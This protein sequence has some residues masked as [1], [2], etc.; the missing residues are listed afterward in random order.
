MNLRT[1]III[2]SMGAIVLMGSNSTLAVNMAGG[3]TWGTPGNAGSPLELGSAASET[4]FLVGV[5][6][7]LRG[8]NTSLDNTKAWAQVYISDGKWWIS[9]RAGHGSGVK[10]TVKCV[11]HTGNRKFLYWDGKGNSGNNY[12]P[13]S[14]VPLSPNRH[15]FLTGVTA[16]TGFTGKYNGQATFVRVRKTGTDWRLTGYLEPRQDGKSGGSATAVCVDIPSK[17][18][19][20]GTWIG[21][22]NDRSE[23]KMGHNSGSMGCFLQ[24][25]SGNYYLSPPQFGWDD[26]VRIFTRAPENHWVVTATSGKGAYVWCVQ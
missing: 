1:N 13:D 8:G 4:C 21:P 9:T 18:S 25:I 20:P 2:L 17:W 15:C 14:F 12:Q 22:A 16:T 3:A 6:G 11:F 10:A 19:G 7:S 5:E 26:G 24:G 23:V